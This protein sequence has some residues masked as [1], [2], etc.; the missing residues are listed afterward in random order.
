MS[1]FLL[2]TFLLYKCDTFWA[3]LMISSLISIL[4]FINF[5]VLAPFK[6]GQKSSQFVIQ[7]RTNG[8]CLDTNFEFATIPRNYL[9]LST[10]HEFSYIGHI[11]IYRSFDIRVH[12]T[13]FPIVQHSN[14]LLSTYDTS[15]FIEFASL[16]GSQ[17]DFAYCELATT[18]S[19]MQ[20]DF[21]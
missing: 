17:F 8:R 15:C 10:C 5:E 3:F 4:P 11:H 12:P 7:Y 20:V 13:I 16:I 18:S 2:S 6:E 14:L 1:T 9:I 21:I 19:P